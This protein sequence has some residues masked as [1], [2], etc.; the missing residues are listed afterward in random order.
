M[1]CSSHLVSCYLNVRGDRDFVLASVKFN[2][3]LYLDLG[4]AGKRNGAPNPLRDKNNFW[5]CCAFQNGFVHLA[6]A[7]IVAGVASRSINNDFTAC[8]SSARV[9]LNCSTF[10]FEGSV[11]RVEHGAERESNLSSVRIEAQADAL[12]LNRRREG[13]HAENSEAAINDVQ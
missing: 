10:Q 13:N 7:A 1:D 3:S 9:E 8:L 6:I 4:F 2:E 12:R 5:I 11:H